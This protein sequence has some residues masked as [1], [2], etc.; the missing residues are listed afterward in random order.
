[1]NRERRLSEEFLRRII[2]QI[3]KGLAYLQSNGYA[4]RD[5]KPDNILVF[6]GGIVKITDFGLARPVIGSQD[7]MTKGA[8][9]PLYAAPEVID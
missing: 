8:C 2:Y 5:M 7:S 3:L 1:M 9:T 6:E 4:H